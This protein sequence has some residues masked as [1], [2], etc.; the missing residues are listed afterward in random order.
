MTVAEAWFDI[1]MFTSDIEKIPKE[2][3]KKYYA[4]QIIGRRKQVL[5]LLDKLQLVNDETLRKY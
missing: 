5:K 3:I 2:K 1:Q 4:D